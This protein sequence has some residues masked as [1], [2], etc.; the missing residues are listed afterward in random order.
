M[1]SRRFFGRIFVLLLYTSHVPL[2]QIESYESYQSKETSER[3]WVVLPPVF[4]AEVQRWPE[5]TPLLIGLAQRDS[6]T[7]MHSVA[8]HETAMKLL[9]DLS[10]L[11]PFPSD[12][13]QELQYRSPALL[14][15][16]AGKDAAHKDEQIA[17]RIVHPKSAVMRPSEEMA[18]HWIHPIMG[19][20]IVAHWGSTQSKTL[21]K[22]TKHWAELIKVH[23]ASL[24]PYF[25]SS[26]TFEHQRERQKESDI[27]DLCMLVVFKVSDVAMAMGLPRPHRES[28]Y[29]KNEIRK[30]I[31][32][33]YLL[34]DE[35]ETLVGN[36]DFPLSEYIVTSVLGSLEQLQGMYTRDEW[37]QPKGFA[38]DLF[39]VPVLQKNGE[40]AVLEKVIAEVW[41][42]YEAWW[43][44]VMLSMDSDG[45]FSRAK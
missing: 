29:T 7:F 12:V 2:N 30:V 41:S 11:F 4:E 13:V 10:L 19:A 22:A 8:V 45:V 1:D 25:E 36:S 9:S 5:L 24:V 6:T 43:V 28:E 3:G 34:P 15:H 27:F 16:D 26:D 42:K 14:L 18:L 39:T 40:S 23:H 17:H 37:I 44:S 38:N 21:Q 35:L 31:Q 32:D 20:D 33:H